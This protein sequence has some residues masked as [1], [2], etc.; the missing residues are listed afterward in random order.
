MSKA[1]DPFARY[2]LARL[3]N[4]SGTETIFG[5]S[6]VGPEVISDIGAILAH[7]V[8]MGE[9][10]AVASHVIARVTGAEAGFVTGCT[11]ASIVIAAAACMTGLDLG[12]IE[13]LPD[14]NRPSKRD[15]YSE[16]PRGQL[17]LLDF[18][19]PEAFRCKGDRS[20]GGDGNRR[21]SAQSRHLS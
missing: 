1:L 3:I 21:L 13:R 20:W 6:P 11:S 17:R 12:R 10:Q 14:A 9:L 18:G 5:A 19:R 8:D 16:G 15:G 7:S 4:A 2:G